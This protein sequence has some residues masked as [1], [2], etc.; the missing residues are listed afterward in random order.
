MKKSEWL[1]PAGLITLSLVPV[2]AGSMRLTELAGGGTVT[3]ENA[4]FFESPIPV[5][6]HIVAS[7]VF[8]VLGALQFAP[9]LRR[10]R[11]H[12]IAGRV[13]VPAGL[14]SALSALWM[15]LFY[16]LPAVNG[17]VMFAMRIGFGTAMATFIVVGFLAIRRGDVATHSAWMTRAYAIGLGAGTQVLTFLPWTLAFGAPGQAMHA[18]LMGAG[19]VINLAV[20]EVVIRRRSARDGRASAAPRRSGA[21]GARLS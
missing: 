11:W 13:L 4:R 10:R 2:L 12:R 17:V 20:A 15:T 9:S 16:A 18:V 5:V 3:A 1:A 8:L 19:W 21:V 6:V 14:L 7:S